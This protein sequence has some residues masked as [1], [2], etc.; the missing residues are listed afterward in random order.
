MKVHDNSGS[1][2]LLK[3]KSDFNSCALPFVCFANDWEKGHASNESLHSSSEIESFVC[4]VSRCKR[5]D[6]SKTECI[7]TGIENYNT[8][9]FLDWRKVGSLVSM[10]A[11]GTVAN[12]P[13]EIERTSKFID[14]RINSVL[15]VTEEKS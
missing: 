2:F 5:P 7:E 12:P 9:A 6:L 1:S 4:R 3:D 10:H 13:E 8:T 11:T 15:F 14:F